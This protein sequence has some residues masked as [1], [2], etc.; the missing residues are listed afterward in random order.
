MD[1]LAR[2]ITTQEDLQ[3]AYAIR[4]EVFVAEQQVSREEEFDEFEVESYH[5]LATVANEAVGTAR[6][7]TTNKGVKLERFA[8]KESHRGKG[9]GKV[10]VVSVLEHIGQVNACGK[11][12]LHAQLDAIS[13]YAH[14]GFEVVGQRFMEC[15]I[16]HQTMELVR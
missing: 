7:R 8:V 5:F 2:L 4:E 12:Y 3:M 15:E 10:L 14:F 6:W 16:E 11:L 13:F 9:V 1:I